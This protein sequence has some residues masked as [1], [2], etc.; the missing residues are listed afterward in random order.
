M[1]ARHLGE[2][3]DEEEEAEECQKDEADYAEVLISVTPTTRKEV[4][5]LTDQ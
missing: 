1:H 3:E 4:T 2:E 5:T